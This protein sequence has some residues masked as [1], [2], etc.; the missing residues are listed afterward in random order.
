[1]SKSLLGVN[2]DGLADYSRTYMFADV[3][4]T[5]RDWGTPS[6][7]WGKDPTIP[8]DA[9]GWPMA[10]AGSCFATE[11]TQ[12]GVYKLSCTGKV[13]SIKAWGPSVQN[14]AYDAATNTTR[15]DIVINKAGDNMYMSLTGTNG[16]FKNLKIMRPGYTENDLFTKEFLNLL[17]PFGRIRF[18]DYLRTN[19]NGDVSTWN[20]RTQPTAARFEIGP[21][22]Y[23]IDLCNA[24]GADCWLCIPHLADDDHVLQLAKLCKQRLNAGNNIYIEFSNEVW[25][26]SFPQAQWNLQQ[27]QTKYGKGG[28][29]V[30]DFLKNDLSVKYSVDDGNGWRWVNYAD[31]VV[32]ISK[33]FKTVWGDDPRL[34]VILSGQ[35]AWTLGMQIGLEYIN[36]FYGAPKDYIYGI[37]GAPYYG[38]LGDWNNRTDLTVDMFFAP[39]N[40]KSADGTKTYSGNNYLMDRTDSTTSDAIKWQVATAK[41]YGI[42]AICYEGGLDL[43]QYDNGIDIKTKLQSDPRMQGVTETY[44]NN[45]F[46]MGGSEFMYF[47]LTSRYTKWGYWGLTDDPYNPQMPKYV[48][49]VNVANAKQTGDVVVPSS[50]SSKPSSSSSSSGTPTNKTIK[51]LALYSKS[52]TLKQIIYDSDLKVTVVYSD[53]SEK[54]LL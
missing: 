53:N 40:F 50:S 11:L 19:S 27:G 28:Y 44:L 15:A 33:I 7:P 35:I 38:G 14:L 47:T 51:K 1:M 24:V 26:Y 6:G 18:M 9:N 21:Y 37:A 49:A 12:A 8:L 30:N 36:K 4:K 3:V 45:W 43:G 41:Q 13:T 48:G 52:G 31:R 20:T 17:K 29:P 46:N 23:A 54:R 2:L 34:R 25:N 32:T 42:K 16:G 5:A 10:D 39:Y 22:E